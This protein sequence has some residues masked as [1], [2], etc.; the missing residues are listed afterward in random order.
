MR[1]VLL[2]ASSLIGV[3]AA[4][5]IGPGAAFAASAGE[6][7][8][9][10]TWVVGATTPSDTAIAPDGSTISLTGTGTLQAGPGHDATGGGTFTTSGGGNGTFTVTG[11][12]GFVSYGN[13]TPQGLPANFF[14]GE[15]KLQVSLSDGTSGVLTVVCELGAP[16]GGKTEGITLILGAG[17]AYSSPDGGNTV[18]VST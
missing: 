9:S 16:P 10:Y 8:G 14:G 11:M 3:V 1:N 4:V 7:H 13:G 18:F 2:G 15:A 6:N 17:G 5:G 12:Q